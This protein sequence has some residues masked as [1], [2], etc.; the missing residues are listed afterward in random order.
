MSDYE[1]LIRDRNLDLVSYL[2]PREGQ[3]SPVSIRWTRHWRN[4][5]VL[6][7]HIP[8]ETDLASELSTIGSFI[9]VRRDGVFEAIYLI[10]AVEVQSGVLTYSRGVQ[11][12]F[13]AVYAGGQGEGTERVVVLRENVP[14][15]ADAGRI[16]RFLDARDVEQTNLPLLIN[17]ADAAVSD[18]S[19]P[20]S[21]VANVGNP[22]AQEMIT[23]WG[24]SPLIYAAGR[25]VLPPPGTR[26]AGSD[27]VQ[28]S[29]DIY[30]RV[31][32]VPADGAMAYYVRQHLVEPN[33]PTRKVPLL[34]I[35]AVGG[36]LP[37]TSYTSRF[38]TV[39]EVLQ[40]L[41]ANNDAGYEIV[42]V[43]SEL[44]FVV[45]PV[46]DRTATSLN[47]V[48]IR[49]DEVLLDIAGRA[50][51]AE[52][53]VGDRITLEL[54]N[55]DRVD[56]RVFEVAGQ[57]EA[58]R[59]VEISLGVTLEAV[60][61]L[62]GGII[63]A[64]TQQG[65]A[66]VRVEP[67]STSSVQTLIDA[68][69]K[70]GI[71]HY[72]YVVDPNYPGA[73][74]DTITLAVGSFAK[75]YTT[76]QAAVD[77]AEAAGVE[78]SILINA[79]DYSG[80]SVVIPASITAPLW[81]HGEA[82]NR[83]QVG[84]LELGSNTVTH[85][86]NIDA[87]A[88]ETVIGGADVEA[89]FE[90]CHLGTVDVDFLHASFRRC[91]LNYFP[92]VEAT[93]NDVTFS[94]C[95]LSMG[96]GAMESHWFTN[97]RIETGGSSP[98]Y[99]SKTLTDLYFS[100]CV[101]E[102]F[103]DSGSAFYKD[104]G[105]GDV[106]F[107]GCEFVIDDTFGA[108]AP[109]NPVFGLVH[110][111]AC[112]DGTL[113]RLVNCAFKVRNPFA[114]GVYRAVKSADPD[115]AVVVVGC[116]LDKVDA[117]ISIT[118]Q[119]KN[120]LFGPNFPV[121]FAVQA[122]AVSLNNVY[123]GTGPVTGADALTV[124]ANLVQ[125]G[126]A[127]PSHD[128]PIGTVFYDAVNFHYYGKKLAGAG[129]GNWFQIDGAG[130]SPG[131]TGP[132]GP[133]GIEG[134]DG[135]EGPP[136]APG[137]PGAAGAAGVAGAAGST[138]IMGPPGDPGEDGETGIVML[139]GG[140]GVTAHS[141][142][143][144]LPAPADDHTQ[145]ALLAGRAGGQTLYGGNAANQNLI[146]GGTSHAT[147]TT[148][149]IS[150]L[151]HVQMAS[152]KGFKDSG[153]TTRILLA[154]A[155]PQ[156]LVT[157]D[158][159][160]TGSAAI[161]SVLQAD[162]W[163]RVHGLSPSA[164]LIGIE[165]GAAGSILL[166]D[167]STSIGIK[168][169]PTFSLGASSTGQEVRA[170]QFVMTLSSASLATPNSFQMVRVGLNIST[171]ANPNAPI[172]TEYVGLRALSP[173]YFGGNMTISNHYGIDIEALAQNAA[174]VIGDRYGIHVGDQ[175]LAMAG[176][177]AAYGVQVDAFDADADGSQFPFAYGD[178]GTE[179]TYINREGALTATQFVTLGNPVLTLTSIATNDDPAEVVYQNRVATT[180]ATVTTI[181]TVT[182]PASTTLLIW[183]VVVARRTGG[184]AGTA[185]DGA[186]YSVRRAYKNVA[187]TATL[188]NA[189]DV[190]ADYTAESQALWAVTFV[191]SGGTVQVRVTGAVSNNVTWHATIRTWAVGS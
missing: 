9:E 18:A 153:G 52:W 89:H 106:V 86:K 78:R 10:R 75:V 83:V 146:L 12:A 126:T 59:A 73:D 174:V 41:G 76:W 82:V 120:S 189:G 114:A 71:V 92:G 56:L 171:T 158:A 62:V 102:S 157:G 172:L 122:D 134:E 169:Q 150:M 50:Y 110:V 5:G 37:N 35:P 137:P 165:I 79:G 131:P 191:V 140:G 45:L 49:D 25:V 54:R 144:G 168:G 133:P 6:E 23:V 24:V 90:D 149:I 105:L 108:W 70:G 185:E 3:V 175:T 119:F 39:L 48:V 141:A 128:A 160:I 77:A 96:D 100:N 88:A 42:R 129:A 14:S 66:L 68:S 187:G 186:A 26:V 117:A 29:G 60:G 123:V 163:L 8:R 162:T 139:S 156:T 111:A 176:G 101:F 57:L 61:D 154:T 170:L 7:L 38:Q 36:L 180:D 4:P 99:S 177:D 121:D 118:G 124:T 84:S 34:T 167:G 152:S 58:G 2:W 190:D 22:V 74:G 15:L 63:D 31:T 53:D 40:D 113:I 127:A 132:M 69:P 98:F 161:G 159:R 13:N 21:A 135:A 166:P 97:C 145:Y 115:C 65:K 55:G 173:G 17:R 19:V 142:L 51:R 136:G 1:L 44:Q 91:T 85:F 27:L 87:S 30:D 188:V 109:P 184:V 95:D 181:H 94:D 72:D 112:T 147:H 104:G 47:P 151:D 103:G 125:R 64:S 164:S 138:G 143:S 16:E 178:V 28:I 11:D 116:D 67:L 32:G 179:R 148:S 43:G 107:D 33:D 81:F 183:A 182:I 20:E 155:S 93:P 46:R 130:G 80:E